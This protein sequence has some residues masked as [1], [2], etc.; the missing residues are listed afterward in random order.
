MGTQFSNIF[1]MFVN[2]EVFNTILNANFLTA[3][4]Y[5][6]FMFHFTV[7]PTVGLKKL[8][9]FPSEQEDN[10]TLSTTLNN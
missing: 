1:L 8:K 9:P 5:I 3:M 7:P 2:T 4:S 10:Q 6:Y